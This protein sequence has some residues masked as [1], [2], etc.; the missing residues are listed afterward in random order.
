M[1]RW[2]T[3]KWIWQK[4]MKSLLRDKKALLT[5]FLPILIYPVIMIFFLGISGI[6]EGN[7]N[8][9]VRHVILEGAVSEE[10][11]E[12]LTEDKRIQLIEKDERSYETMM[13]EEALDVVVRQ[14]TSEAGP[15]VTLLFNSTIDSSQRGK[16]IV[17]NLL[18]DYK[19]SIVDKTLGALDLETSVFELVILE[20]VE[21]T[22][23]SSSN[24]A[25]A[26]ILGV[27][28]PFILVMY[29]IIGIY[30]ISS[31]LSVGEKERCTLET[32]FSVQIAKTNIILGKLF[33]GVTVGLLSGL[34]NILSMFPLMYGIISML[35]ESTFKL[36]PV[37]PVFVLLMLLPIMFLTCAI[38]VGLGLFAK[39]YQEAQN[40]GAFVM[41]AF[42]LPAYI[43]LIPDITF[44]T[45]MALIP[46]SNGILAMR[47][48]FVGDYSVNKILITLGVNCGIA[49]IAVTGMSKVF[50]SEN[51]IFG[52]G[53]GRKIDF[54]RWFGGRYE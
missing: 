39:T 19:T 31:D 53:S 2:Q 14:Q 47:D 50:T 21:V 7:L 49:I 51:V 44:S 34:T 29:S 43:G 3:I 36:S 22:E 13:R 10:M 33:A 48:A 16:R 12:A 8:E 37:L 32:I 30:S 20:T 26:S 11:K 46:I 4:E 27:V 42:M 5:I 9:E 54:K 17:E 41:I 35:P 28:A 38:M 15:Q 40:Y 1:S 18:R 23:D 6:V 52:H 45:N 25:I 24:R